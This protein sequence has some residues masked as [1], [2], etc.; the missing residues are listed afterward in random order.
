MRLDS[1]LMAFPVGRGVMSVPYIIARTIEE[2][3]KHYAAIKSDRFM[4]ND[5][6]ILDG[7]NY[8]R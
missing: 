8:L 1:E 3:R 7:K 2:A 5:A 4:L 6:D